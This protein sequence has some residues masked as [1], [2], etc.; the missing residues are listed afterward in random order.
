MATT[1][2][3][4]PSRDKFLMG[5]HRIYIPWVHCRDSVNYQYTNMPWIQHGLFWISLMNTCLR[6]MLPICYLNIT[7]FPPAQ[8]ILNLPSL[9]LRTSTNFVR[10]YE[11][12][13]LQRRQTR[14]IRNID[15]YNRYKWFIGGKLI[16]FIILTTVYSIRVI[17]NR[18]TKCFE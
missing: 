11:H 10:C 7:D 16:S 14:V 15:A 17:Y 5:A 8:K 2:I 4:W 3:T 13:V 9:V 1:M 6:S 12:L 18:A